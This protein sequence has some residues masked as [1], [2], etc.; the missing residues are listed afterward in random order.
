M[1]GFICY[2][3]QEV[4]HE[5]GS[6]VITCGGLSSFVNETRCQGMNRAEAIPGTVCI[7]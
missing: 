1:D 4:N 3:G 5:M 2:T 6:A 7:T